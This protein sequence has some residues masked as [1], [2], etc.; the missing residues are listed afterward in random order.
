MS[1]H[2]RV[3]VEDNIMRLVLARPEKKNALTNAMYAALGAALQRA[4]SDPQVRVVLLEAEGD[5]FTAGNDIG[6]F[7]AVA[8]GTADRSDM[9][10]FAFLE[11]LARGQKPYVAAVHGFAVGIGVTMLMHFDLVYVAEDAKLSTPFVNL[12]VVPEAASSWLIPAR[13]GHARAFAMFALGEAIDGRT[14][15][16]LGM[17]NSALPASEVRA[18]ALAAA[19]VLAAKPIGALQATKKLMRDAEAISALIAREGEIFGARL[20]TAEAAEA[21]RAFAE[22]RAPDF[23]KIEGE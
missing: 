9:Q 1:D 19:K 10:A 16:S 3:S 22:R 6:D 5:A 12:A 4:E 21:F 18:K 2:I 15:A 20:R 17:A 14:A 7:A 11:A 23:S 13:I 8:A